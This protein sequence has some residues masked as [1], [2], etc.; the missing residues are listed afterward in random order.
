ML[1]ICVS[2][3]SMLLSIIGCTK[4]TIKEIA[5]P[6]VYVHDT[7]LVTA[8]DT[9]IIYDTITVYDTVTIYDTTFLPVDTH[10]LSY[11]AWVASHTFV[12]DAFPE[13]TF[14]CFSS[15]TEFCNY[16]DDH[17]PGRAGFMLVEMQDGSYDAIGYGIINASNSGF[18]AY[19]VNMTYGNGMWTMNGAQGGM[20]GAWFTGRKDTCD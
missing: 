18:F 16:T 8:N 2:L 19:T 5:G 13:Q 12:T 20:A 1:L 17:P 9:I 14:N 11:T 15:L 4:E 6:T 10:Y 7:T 3:C